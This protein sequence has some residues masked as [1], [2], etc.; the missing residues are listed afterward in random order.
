LYSELTKSRCCICVARLIKFSQHFCKPHPA[1]IQRCARPASTPPLEKYYFAL[2]RGLARNRSERP[3]LA[4][5]TLLLADFATGLPPQYRNLCQI[6][7]GFHPY[8]ICQI[9][10]AITETA[11]CSRFGDHNKGSARLQFN[12]RGQLRACSVAAPD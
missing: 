7:W 12:S 5:R 2:V 6:S 11:L 4:A 9:S 8:D 3:C 10:S 1:A